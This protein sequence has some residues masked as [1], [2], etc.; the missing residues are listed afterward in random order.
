MTDENDVNESEEWVSKSQRKREMHHRQ[1]IGEKILA[2]RA[3]QQEQLNLPEELMRAIEE[4]SRIKKNEAL[5]RHKQYI[6]KLMRDIDLAP[7]EEFL[8]RQ[9]HSHQINTRAFHDL[10]D[11]RERLILG[12]NKTIGEAIEKYPAI[13]RQKLRQLVRNAQKERRVN[14]AQNTSDNKQGRALFRFLRAESESLN[15]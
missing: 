7:I 8:N 5:R 6:G 14:E 3:S 10:E 12:D 15:G 11:L 9:E 2:L 4:A 1:E 13:D